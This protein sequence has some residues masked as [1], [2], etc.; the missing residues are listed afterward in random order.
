MLSLILFVGSLFALQGP[1]TSL[2]ETML[3]AATRAPSR[4]EAKKFSLPKY[5]RYRGQVVTD[6]AKK[7]PAAKA[8]ISVGDVIFTLNGVPV[9]ST[10]SIDDIL[11]MVKPKKKVPMV[12]KRV[13]TRKEETI[14]LVFPKPAPKTEGVVWQYAGMKL[15]KKVSEDWL[16]EAQETRRYIL[17]G[18][19]GSEI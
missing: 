16:K 5:A 3:G 7:S 12:L 11:R 4:E 13:K 8:G 10:D 1:E 15:Q 17:V 2:T 18:L 19:S 9:Y 14:H 6:V